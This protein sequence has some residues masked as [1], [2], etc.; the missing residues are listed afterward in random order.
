MKRFEIPW[1]VYKNLRLSYK[2]ARD[3]G[4]W[5]TYRVLDDILDAARCIPEPG[6][7]GTVH[8][9]TDRCSCIVTEMKDE[10]TAVVELNGIYEGGFTFTKRE[11]GRWIEKGQNEYDG[12]VL[13]LGYASNY[14]YEE[15]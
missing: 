7:P 12:L 13:T 8:Y 9:Y 1:E 10:K 11:S 2:T 6:C 3:K 15:I 5:D 14:R 4:D